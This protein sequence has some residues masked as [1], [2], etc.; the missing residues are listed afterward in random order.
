MSAIR[1]LAPRFSVED[2]GAIARSLYG[3][4]RFVR[5]L[6]SE[7][8]QN[9][10]FQSDD[11]QEFTLKIANRDEDRAVLDFQ[12]R[13]MEHVAQGP[14]VL[15][16]LDGQ[17][18]VSVDGPDGRAHYVRLVSFI[19]GVPLA[20]FRPHSSRL[21]G[22]L[23]RALGNVDKS[24]STFSHPAAG[25]ELYWNIRN[26]ERV[27]SEYKHLI[28]DPA[29][30]SIVETIL[31]DWVQEVAPR[32]PVLRTSVIHNDA[33]DYN[34]IVNDED[35][36]GLIDFGD[37]LETFTVSEPAIA[38]AYVMLDKPDPIAAAADLIRGY[39]GPHPLRE[40]E[41]DLIYHFIRTRL[42]MSV[43][44]AAHQKKLEP[45]NE[46]LQI[47]ER[48]AWA[49]LEKLQDT[50]PRLARYILRQACGL[51]ACPSSGAVASFLR[52][53]NNVTRI[54]APDLATQASVVIDLSIGSL[55]LGSTDE[56]ANVET[57]TRVL[58][59]RLEDAGAE[60]GI[61]R[62]NEARGVYTSTLFSTPSNDG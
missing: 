16:T 9:F 41:V 32:F 42:A 46:Y 31:N 36:I 40:L 47:S 45:N 29:R 50:H 62:Y 2:A 53:Q 13:A 60:L 7:R 1:S 58:F 14:R 11:G 51:S 38:C 28:G 8:D 33:N 25:R 6:P 52:A 57:A 30:R 34:V 19:P 23:G 26:A 56:L 15:A 39:N 22:N 24:L 49:L 10:L 4:D 20:N 5:E 59:R 43:T 21:L 27:I 18:I 48:P 37:M 54:V 17:Q 35:T 44:I 55:E 61:G 3:L 12:N